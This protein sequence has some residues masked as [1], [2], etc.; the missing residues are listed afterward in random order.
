MGG[1]GSMGE[2]VTADAEGSVIAG[3]VGPVQGLTKFVPQ[4]TRASLT[5][6]ATSEDR[7]QGWAFPFAAGLLVMGGIMLGAKMFGGNQPDKTAA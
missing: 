4:L 7:K 5:L 3:E 6:G 1:V 2:G